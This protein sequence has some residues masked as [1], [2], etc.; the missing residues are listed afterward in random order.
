MGLVQ[1]LAGIF[2]CA[3]TFACLGVEAPKATPPA[4]PVCGGSTP[5]GV[6]A[7]ASHLAVLSRTALVV[8]VD[9]TAGGGLSGV[10]LSAR[11]YQGHLVL[12]WEGASVSGVAEGCGVTLRLVSPGMDSLSFDLIMS[13]SDVTGWGRDLGGASSDS[14]VTFG[15][16]VNG[17]LLVNADQ[18][19]PTRLD[20]AVTYVQVAL[21]DAWATDRP[22]IAQLQARNLPFQVAAPTFYV[23]DGEHLTWSDLR[24]LVSQGEAVSAHSVY[25][26]P[27]TDDQISFMHEVLVSAMDLEAHGIVPTVFTQPGVWVDSLNFDTPGKLDTW[28]GSLI[29]E[30][31]AG[32]D[33]YT[34]GPLVSLPMTDS[35][36]FGV[37]HV[38]LD[39]LTTPELQQA[40]WRHALEGDHFVSWIIH[41]KTMSDS[42]Q[43]VLLFDSL[44]AA[45][46]SHRVIVV[47]S[48]V[49]A[50]GVS[51]GVSAGSPL[52]GSR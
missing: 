49:D 38:T 50:P 42:D 4:A 19:F 43:F 46:S 51:T 41:T 37:S 22:V 32:F 20:T 36:R 23:N 18:V 11:D 52:P 34:T 30:F 29:R 15:M 2:L 9:S 25:H 27:T 8:E 39:N 47:P 12:P 48:L 24:T 28:R 17:A 26:V 3:T 6:W 1:A 45:V 44:S 40:F 33:A 14:Q 13:G 5:Y 16:K 21:H 35:S 7:I 31:Y 10:L